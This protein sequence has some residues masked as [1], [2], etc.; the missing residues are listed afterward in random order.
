MIT[1]GCEKIGVDLHV[2]RLGFV[3]GT[4]HYTDT[5][6]LFLKNP[7]GIKYKYSSC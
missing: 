4:V 7:L 6:M 1:T 2:W 5:S 3:Q